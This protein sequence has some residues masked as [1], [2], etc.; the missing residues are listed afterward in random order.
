MK[1]VEYSIIGKKSQEA[2]EDGL[3][4]TD[5]FIAVTDGFPVCLSGVKVV[6]LKGAREV[7]F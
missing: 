7:V 2:C 6:S 5:D 1:I 3:V 4:M